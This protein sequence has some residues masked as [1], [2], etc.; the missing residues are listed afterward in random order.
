MVNASK[1]HPLALQ[2]LRWLAQQPAAIYD[3]AVVADAIGQPRAQVEAA[4]RRLQHETTGCALSRVG[5]KGEK[6]RPRHAYLPDPSEGR[7]FAL[8]PP[9][10]PGAAKG[11]DRIKVRASKDIAASAARAKREA[12]AAAAVASAEKAEAEKNVASFLARRAE[13]KAALSAAVRKRQ[14]AAPAKPAEPTPKPVA[15]KTVKPAPAK[16]TAPNG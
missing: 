8:A 6:L 7:K 14:E 1:V 2:V 11:I 9:P 13:R 5:P 15:L 10:P 12:D 4:I 16:E 3:F